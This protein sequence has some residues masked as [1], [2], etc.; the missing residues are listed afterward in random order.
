MSWRKYSC[1]SVFTVDACFTMLKILL[2]YAFKVICVHT[3]TRFHYHY[4]LYLCKKTTSLLFEEMFIVQC[5]YSAEIRRYVD[6]E[7]IG[8]PAVLIS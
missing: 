8:M 5:V 6:S 1:G 4:I 3:V 7:L 2:F